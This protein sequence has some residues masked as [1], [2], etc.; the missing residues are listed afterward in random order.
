MTHDARQTRQ[1]CGVH[2]LRC[3]QSVL[4][5]SVK[6]A[7]AQFPPNQPQSL[8][9]LAHG[10]LRETPRS[11]PRSA[12]NGAFLTLTNE[13]GDTSPGQYQGQNGIVRPDGSS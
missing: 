12:D 10:A 11:T 7:V 5:F 2:S 6:T 1:H 4:P 13:N 8:P 9:S 3:S